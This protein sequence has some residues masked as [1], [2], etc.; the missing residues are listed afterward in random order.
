M[1]KHARFLAAFLSGLGVTGAVF[2]APTFQ[3]RPN[4]T[5]LQRMRG[6]VERVGGTMRKVMQREHDRQAAKD[7]R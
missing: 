5:D 3:H 1:N 2:S 7:A 4:G 6:D